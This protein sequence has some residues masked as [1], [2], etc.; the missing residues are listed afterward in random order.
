MVFTDFAEA[1]LAAE[2]AGMSVLG[3]CKPDAEP[4]YLLIPKDAD[5]L[6]CRNA[7]FEALVGRPI[8]DG[9]EYLLEL[10]E[11]RAAED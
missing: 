2:A 8:S 1:T 5:E 11:S 3:T 6:A 7:A 10:V 4:T 9:E